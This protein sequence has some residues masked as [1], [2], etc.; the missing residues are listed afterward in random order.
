[1]FQQNWL[2]NI[3]KRIET[4]VADE[5]GLLIDT[6]E[7]VATDTKVSNGLPFGGYE[8]FDFSKRCGLQKLFTIRLQDASG[9]ILLENRHAIM[10]SEAIARY[11][12]RQ[13]NG[14]HVWSADLLNLNWLN[15]WIVLALETLEKPYFQAIPT[16]SN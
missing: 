4:T 9:M 13:Q 5:D 7:A 8:F 10:V 6:I 1:M 16:Y 15:N 3:G 14:L 11:H 12:T 2:V